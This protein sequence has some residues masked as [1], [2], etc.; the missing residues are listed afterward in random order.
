MSTRDIL[1]RLKSWASKDNLD[2]TQELS[3][4]VPASPT[5][6]FKE[7]LTSC[8]PKSLYTNII[9]RNIMVKQQ[10]IIMKVWKNK[11]KDQ[12]LITIPKNCSIQEGD[13]VEIKKV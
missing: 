2:G 9:L 8:P 12:K 1:P 10:K 4:I 5:T 11:A 7:G 13:Y 6:A 3:N